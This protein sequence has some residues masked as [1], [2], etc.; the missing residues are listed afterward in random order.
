MFT[1]HALILKGRELEMVCVAYLVP[2][3]QERKYPELF[4]INRART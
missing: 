3:G 4:A 2:S 1:E